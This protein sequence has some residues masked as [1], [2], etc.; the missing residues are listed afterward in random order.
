MK[1]F[2]LNLN[3]RN[4]NRKALWVVLPG[5]AVCCQNCLAAGFGNLPGLFVRWSSPLAIDIRTGD[6][7][8]LVCLLYRLLFS[9]G[10]CVDVAYNVC[11]QSPKCN[12][13]LHDIILHRHKLNTK[14]WITQQYLKKK[15]AT[16]YKFKVSIQNELKSGYWKHLTRNKGWRLQM[17]RI[18]PWSPLRNDC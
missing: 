12:S 4:C 11:S 6:N 5:L 16:W 10:I 7:V 1:T 13:V 8:Y 14:F 18:V 17:Q 3:H 15:T 9:Y 2:C